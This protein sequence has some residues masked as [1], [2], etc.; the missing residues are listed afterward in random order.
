MNNDRLF[1]QKHIF[2]CGNERPAGHPRGCCKEKGGVEL[3]NYMKARVKEEGIGN[4]RVNMA[5][6]L[7]RCELGPVMVIYP[8]GDWYTFASKDDV[9]EIIAALKNNTKA[10]RLLLAKDQTALNP[11]QKPHT[12]QKGTGA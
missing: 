8:D 1:Y 4:T 2:C 12:G 5:G 9:D 6:C 11:D 7:D 10:A 3:R